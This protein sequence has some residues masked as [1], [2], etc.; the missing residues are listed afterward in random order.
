VTVL[1]VSDIRAT[2]ILCVADRRSRTGASAPRHAESSLAPARMKARTASTALFGRLPATPSVV[3]C[4]VGGQKAMC[5][6]RKEPDVTATFEI[7]TPL[8]LGDADRDID[9]H[10]PHVR[11]TSIK[12]AWRFWW[13]VVNWP[14]FALNA[15]DEASALGAMRRREVC[16][17]GA[18]A[19]KRGR[20][21]Q[22]PIRF[23]PLTA[24]LDTYPS[25]RDTPDPAF[26]G[27]RWVGLRYAGYGM[28]VTA[29]ETEKTRL[30]G[31]RLLRRGE[32]LRRAFREGQQFTVEIGLAP[33]LGD[34][35]RLELLTALKWLG[36]VGGL[37]S[38]CR[39]G[40]G[41]IALRQLECRASDYRFTCPGT[42]TDYRQ[43]LA[44]LLRAVPLGEDLPPITALSTAARVDLVAGPELP[45]Q[46]L[47]RAGRRLMLLRSFGYRVD[48]NREVARGE[49][50]LQLF[51]GDRKIAQAEKPARAGVPLRTIFGCPHGY[52]GYRRRVVPAADGGRRASPLLFHVHPIAG[53][54]ERSALVVMVLPALFTPGNLVRWE[55]QRGGGWQSLGTRRFEPE[56]NVLHAFLDGR[57]RPA[58]S[59]GPRD[60]GPMAVGDERV[61]L[62]GPACG[63]KTAAPPSPR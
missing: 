41:S 46:M 4:R 16:L 5:P 58:D 3:F 61:P 6:S 56:W 42:F 60:L 2:M 19:D 39:R 11:V 1:R 57:R 13:R 48:S 29:D 14:R 32:L 40:F 12:G 7:A 55:E 45:T 23:C 28:V 9:P 63:P 59:K 50:A 52:V 10:R 44:R 33:W 51:T 27:G 24:P 37:G 30:R 25:W 62:L 22:S 8:F 35:D 54:K 18:P 31:R 15:T 20:E 21:G 26:P 43:E 53:A 17:F 49:K 38:R 34:A 36:L 47:N